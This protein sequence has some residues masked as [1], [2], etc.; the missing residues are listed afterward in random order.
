MA[1]QVTEQGRKATLEIT[2]MTCASCSARIEKK[3][4]KVPGVLH[5]NVNLATEKATVE[6]DPARVDESNLVDTVTDLGYGV[7]ERQPENVTF[8]VTGM[9]CASC[10]ARIERTLNKLPGV[11][12]AGVNLA[13][14]KATV[15]FDP[16]KLSL[17]DLRHA[18]ED[19]GVNAPAENVRRDVNRARNKAAVALVLG[20]LIFLGSAPGMLPDFDWVPTFLRNPY[21]LW[22]LATPVQ[23]WA[24]WQFYR[25]A[26]AAARH[27][28]A[29][30]N[31]LIAVG[32][33]SAYLYSAAAVL[34]P[35][36]F[37]AAGQ[38]AALY[39][40]TSSVI[41]GLILLGKYLEARAC[42]PISFL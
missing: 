1:A 22:A 36:L 40:D 32:T 38:M 6:F 15:L 30:M 33:S 2:G 4:A 7:K 28:S 34:F 14:E 26:W 42:M 37:H 5:A 25:G 27:M 8:G 18:V 10:S 31:T 20:A 21:V 35:E 41:I 19:V 9:T 13:T 11:E 39:F 23:F 24:G 16:A 3:L 12:T 17:A 29:D